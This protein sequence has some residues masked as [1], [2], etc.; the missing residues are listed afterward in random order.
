M[1][2]KELKSI[3]TEELKKAWDDIEMVKHC[4]KSTAFVIEHNGALYGIEKPRIE[5]RFYFGYGMNGISDTE[6]EEATESMAEMAQKSKEYFIKQNQ[7]NLNRWITSHQEIL[8]DKGR[9]WAEGSHPR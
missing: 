3:Y 1:T 4:S 9:N 5:T 2:Q 7:K 6:Q 8:T